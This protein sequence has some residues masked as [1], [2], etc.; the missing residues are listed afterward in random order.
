MKRIFCAVMATL[1]AACAAGPRLDGAAKLMADGNFAEAYVAYTNVIFAVEGEETPTD[2]DRAQALLDAA[3]CVRKVS[4]LSEVEPLLEKARAE[5]GEFPVRLA[6]VQALGE[7][8]HT[9]RMVKGR[10]VRGEGWRGDYSSM[11]RDRVVRLRWLEELMPA[12]AAQT[13]LRQRWFW[14][15]TVDALMMNGRDAECAWKLVDLTDL[16]A[17][18]EVVR[19]GR[20]RWALH[21]FESAPAPVDGEGRPVFHAV[22]KSWSAAH[23]DGE[24]W[25]AANAARAAVDETGRM[26]SAAALASFAARQFGVQ[27]LGGEQNAAALVDD[28][29]SLADDETIARVANGVQRFKLPEDYCYIRLWELGANTA[30]IANE[31]EMR[32][33]FARAA[34]IYEKTD[35]HDSAK[36][37]TAP[38]VR[39]EGRVPATS[40]KR[41]GTF[42]ITHRNAAEIL[43]SLQRIDAEKR[44]SEVRDFVKSGVVTNDWRATEW[45]RESYMQGES[46]EALAKYLAG[47]KMEWRVAVK[48]A[49][50][51]FDTRTEVAVPFDLEPGD[52]MLRAEAPGG[53]C[54][55]SVLRV[56]RLAV[57]KETVARNGW[58][59]YRVVDAETGAPM[60][61]VK[62][63]AFMWS[64]DY[65][66]GRPRGFKWKEYQAVTDEAGFAVLRGG[67]H[68]DAYYS[69]FV[70][71]R[72]PDGS[73]AVVSTDHHGVPGLENPGRLRRGVIIT[74]R[75]AYRPGDTIKYK[76]WARRREGHKEPLPKKGVCRLYMSGDGSGEPLMSEELTFDSFG[77]AS[78]EFR[79]P[80]DA[81][82]G[83]YR[84]WYEG[85]EIS[86][87]VRVE[88]YRKP[89]FEVAVDAPKG[90]LAL[91]EKITATVRAKYYFGEPVKRGRANVTVRR[92]PRRADWH[93][94]CEW[95]WLYGGGCCWYFY[96]SD[97][98]AGP[99]R[100][101][102]SR[103]SP[104]Q[105]YAPPGPAPETVATMTDVPLDENGEVKVVW[106][107]SFA[108]KLYGDVDQEYSIVASVMDESRRT[109]DGSGSVVARAEPFRVFAWTDRPRYRVGDT[110]EANS[111]VDGLD[112][113]EIAS[114]K[115]R[116]YELSASGEE[117]AGEGTGPRFSA[118]KPGQYRISCEVT[119]VK[120]RTREGSRIITVSGAGD[121]GRAFRYAALELVPDKAFYA[122]GEKVRLAIN[123]DYPGSTV[124]VK[125][126]GGETQV[127][128][129]APG[130]KTAEIGVDVTEGDKPN[131][132]IEA[133]TV[134]ADRCHTETRE[135]M[136]PPAD[137][138]GHAAVE[139]EGGKD[140]VFKP[141]E[142]VAATVRI[143]DHEGAP[144]DASAVI[145]VYD[146]AIDAIAGGSN[147]KEL[148]T[149]FWSARRI[150]HTCFNGFEVG[151]ESWGLR[152]K[153]D[154]MCHPLGLFGINGL[155]G[156][157]LGEGVKLQGSV[158]TLPRAEE[159]RVTGAI[160]RVAKMRV[161]ATDEIEEESKGLSAGELEEVGS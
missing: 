86:T 7:L 84:L 95:D 66:G 141:G 116:L 3:R 29:A 59:G 130:A 101:S 145:T 120:G 79:L 90:A 100:L 17:V 133:W 20:W 127:V 72:A 87:A 138:I 143:F 132:Y 151:R 113:D 54:V 52:Y 75:P 30:A 64:G 108:R 39:F 63:D 99:G 144:A 42:T 124:F 131:F 57:V 4:R 50:G 9:G 111:H 18:P 69:G 22:P 45:L 68:G 34:A 40:W 32:Y 85:F 71:C 96:D 161:A 135:V 117:P 125:T 91:G 98:Y 148:K 76:M 102:L 74:D 136:V 48:Q 152:L 25:R 92:S 2:G 24:R 106:D 27:T 159:P 81:K 5:R 16:G 147:V 47:E 153:G 107:T 160:A 51:H 23:T 115:W 119:D 149:A 129:M 11:E 118:S 112:E 46:P 93:P 37:I 65:Y 139:V 61:G 88:E 55:H 19:R 12:V 33:Q 60:A 1:W 8:P 21:D 28:L 94:V 31:F 36:R 154:V 6:C 103:V 134:T 58:T 137:K 35:R 104:W 80:A 83:E 128:R 89:E 10:F 157:S 38:G 156:F 122:P 82:L 126:R 123:T 97:W 110:I 26:R 77:G 109:I 14:N 67:S 49:A 15:E 146:K 142:R 158:K 62:L 73:T 114:R 121:D 105:G 150:W 41:R 78:G 70:V 56:E 140:G 43:F 155:V 13:R 53:G 44:L